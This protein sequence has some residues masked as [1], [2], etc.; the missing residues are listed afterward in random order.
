MSRLVP[1][2]SEIKKYLQVLATTPKR[3]KKTSKG[4]S[5]TRLSAKPN[6]R[7]WSAVEILAHLRGATDL[8]TYSIYAMLSENTPALALLDERRWAKAARYS[9]LKFRPSLQAFTLQRTELLNVLRA[10][11]DSH[12]SRTASVGGRAHSVYS[13]VRRLA[14]HELDHCAQIESLLA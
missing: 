7:A 9:E 4:L 12:W 5:E 13:Q 14:M 2:P 10:I 1:V 8:W 11:P 6:D 3:L